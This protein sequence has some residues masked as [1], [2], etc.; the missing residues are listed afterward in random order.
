MLV[1]A[2]GRTE[3]LRVTQP[4]TGVLGNENSA[5]STNPASPS[6]RSKI[7]TG[8]PATGYESFRLQ[9]IERAL[10]FKAFQLKFA[11]RR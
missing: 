11:K 2:H 4:R 6:S 10:L 5:T 1:E 9:S 3:F 8:I 7:A